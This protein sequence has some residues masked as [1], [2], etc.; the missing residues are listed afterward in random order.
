MKYL[1]NNAMEP[2]YYT[3]KPS[4]D[5]PTIELQDVLIELFIIRVMKLL[6]S[7]RPLFFFLS[8]CSLYADKLLVKIV[9][10]VFQ[11]MS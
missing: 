10:P 5:A 4:R 1:G 7:L 6:P 9:V 11:A 3:H 8:T 2:T